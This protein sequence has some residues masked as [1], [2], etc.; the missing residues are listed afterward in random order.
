MSAPADK[1][2]TQFNLGPLGGDRLSSQS[3]A[4]TQPPN[5]RKGSPFQE[6]PRKLLKGKPRGLSL[7]V[8]V[9]SGD[10]AQQALVVRNESPWDTFSR[11]YECELAGPVAVVERIV[12]PSTV[13]AV[14]EFSKEAIDETLDRFKC[15][16]HDNII[17]AQECFLTADLLYVVFEHQPVSL[18]HLVACR[19]WPNEIQLASVVAQVLNGLSHLAA[20]GLEH[21][22]LSC[23]G[24]LVGC[25][26]SVK[27]AR[28][29]SCQ[30]RPPN[31]PREREIKALGVV[32]ME[33]M[34]KDAKEE[35]AIGVSD[36]QRWPTGSDAV[37]FLSATTSTDWL[38]E[39]MKHPL[40]T[41]R[42]W[43]KGYL[44]GL[45]SFALISA[46]TFYSRFD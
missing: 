41:R 3:P 9:S 4:P 22:S 7:P 45:V 23:S 40:L 30:P 1:R 36:L 24:V 32:V 28:L 21:R 25:D 42:R 15:I 29:E 46:R 43:S 6:P 20:N 12:R 34:D 10:R 14:R 11:V 33:L 26:G 5:K 37:G 35:G 2:Y 17:L 16:R 44:V 38:D 8:I 39:L 19:K 13:L 27:I 31:L 18:D